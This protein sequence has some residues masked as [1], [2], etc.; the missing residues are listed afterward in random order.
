M[1][2]SKQFWNSQQLQGIHN[3]VLQGLHMKIKQAAIMRIIKQYK[4]RKREDLL[5][6]EHFFAK[7]Y[8]YSQ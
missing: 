7:R 1:R 5:P 2:K 6:N 4:M 3:N 8:N